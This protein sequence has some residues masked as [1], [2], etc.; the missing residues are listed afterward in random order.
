M[1]HFGFN[2]IAAWLTKKVLSAGTISLDQK[3]HV[4]VVDTQA[5]Q[6]LD[7]F[8]AANPEMEEGMHFRAISLDVKSRALRS[9]LRELQKEEVPVTWVCCNFKDVLLNLHALTLAGGDSRTESR[10]Q[11]KRQGTAPDLSGGLSR[12]AAVCLWAARFG[13]IARGG[14]KRVAGS[15]GDYAQSNV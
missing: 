12:G 9:A 3:V 15:A 13:V 11:H 8:L 10:A 7:A 2:D 14:I 6:K 1:L 4:T 5:E